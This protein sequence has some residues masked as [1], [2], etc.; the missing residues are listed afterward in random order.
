M[1]DERRQRRRDLGIEVVARLEPLARGEIAP[2]AQVNVMP[3]Q[4]RD[5]RVEEVLC[6][7]T[8]HRLQPLANPIEQP[9]ALGDVSSRSTAMRFMKNSSRLEPKIARNLTRSSSGVRWSRASASTRRLNSSQLNSQSIH[10]VE[11]E[12]SRMADVGASSPG[13]A[14]G[15][16]SGAASPAS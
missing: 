5:D 10:T 16:S 13:D 2:A 9:P 12:E 7:L 15:L 3:R 14:E 4:L 6:L 11:S 1:N 8:H